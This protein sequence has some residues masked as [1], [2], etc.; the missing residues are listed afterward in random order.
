MN[1]N[2]IIMQ[3]HTFISLQI[4]FISSLFN[5]FKTSGSSSNLFSEIL[6]KK[7]RLIKHKL[8]STLTINSIKGYLHKFY[9]EL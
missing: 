5:K 8:K 7:L 4:L 1:K 3:N 9:C 6:Y 2:L